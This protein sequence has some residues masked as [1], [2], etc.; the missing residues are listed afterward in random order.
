MKS[1]SSKK[2]DLQSLLRNRNV[3]YIVLFFSVMNLFCY[4][5]MKQLDAVAFFIIIGFLTTYFSKN[6]IIV[7]LTSVLSTFF[8][9]QIK[10]LGRVQEGMDTMKEKEDKEEEEEKED[11]EEDM[12][13]A[14]TKERKTMSEPPSAMNTSEIPIS[15]AMRENLTSIKDEKGLQGKKPERFTQKLNPARYN[16]SDDD[17]TPRH[18]PKIDYAATLETAYDDL[19]KLLSSDAIKNMS[20]DTG[21]LADKQKQ[22]MSNIEKLTPIMDKASSVLS[23]LDM[24]GISG[25]MGGIQDRLKG[26]KK[27]AVIP[28][29][30]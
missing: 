23:N 11:E 4:L 10:M 8:L 13:G 20:E 18:K 14:E 21:R 15:N 2:I 7:M 16:A 3:L 25:L 30:K 22:L 24:G 28:E 27:D 6:M 9:V 12:E 5:M 26:F 17:T 19:D 1:R 29:D